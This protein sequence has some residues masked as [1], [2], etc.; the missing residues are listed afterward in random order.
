MKTTYSFFRKIRLLC[1]TG[2]IFCCFA[3]NMNSYGQNVCISGTGAAP[4]SAALLDL[5][6][7]NSGIWIPHMTFAQKNAISLAVAAQGL[8]VFQTDGTSGFYYNTSATTTPSWSLLGGSGW[9]FT[10]NSGLVDATNNFMGTLDATPVKFITNGIGNVRMTIASA[11]NIGIGTAPV[12][13]ALLQIG[14][15]TANSQGLLIPQVQLVATNNSSSP[16]SSPATGL[17]VYNTSTNGSGSTAVY[18]GFYYYTGSSWVPFLDGTP[19]NA[20]WMVTGNYGTTASTSAYGTAANNNYIGTNTNADLVFVANTYERMRIANG[21]GYVGIGNSSP[22]SLFSVG[23]GSPFQVDLNGNLVKINGVTYTWP[24][25]N[26]GGS[27]PNYVLQNTDGLGTLAW[28]NSNNAGQFDR[29]YFWYTGADQKFKVP[30]GVTTINVKLW[31][32]GGEHGSNGSITKNSQGGSGA[33]VSATLTVTPGQVITV[34]V[35]G[36]GVYSSLLGVYGGG[37]AAMADKTTIWVGGGGGM[38]ALQY[39]AGTYF[40]IA[41]GGGGGAGFYYNAGGS[42]TSGYGNGGGTGAWRCCLKW[43]SF[44]QPSN[45]Y[46]GWWYT[47]CRGAAGTEGSG[48]S[49]GS[50]YTGGLGGYTANRGYGGGGG[51]GWYGGGGGGGGATLGYDGGG[52]GGS[53]YWTNVPGVTVGSPSSTAGNTGAA[54]GT[55]PLAPLILV[56]LIMERRVYRGYGGGLLG[57]YVYPGGNGEVVIS[58]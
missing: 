12:A 16:I 36:G 34:I 7:T 50:Q 23:A 57:G 24:A 39:P 4:N 43:N 5:E 15:G 40:M 42:E 11:G 27:N 49:A 19:P 25:T 45:R 28:S 44:L 20:G 38:S 46:R 1:A 21:T 18:T 22:T 56:M 52:G 47:S 3:G 6:S 10:G 30:P 54:N 31:G 48:G 51:G 53:S 9:G 41:G 55:L 14:T 26:P 32:G 2:M 58:W 8:L 35:G 13:T 33:Y 17:L 37:G 29:V